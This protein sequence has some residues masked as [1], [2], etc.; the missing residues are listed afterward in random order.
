[1]RGADVVVVATT[2]QTPCCRE[3]ACAGHP[4]QRR[5]APRPTWRS[6]HD[7]VAAQGSLY[8]EQRE[9]ATRNPGSHRRARSSP[10]SARSSRGPS[11]AGNRGRDHP[12]QVGSGVA[13][14]GRGVGRSRL[15][16]ALEA[17]ASAH[18]V[19]RKPPGAGGRLAQ[20]LLRESTFSASSQHPQTARGGASLRI[21][22]G[23]VRAARTRRPSDSIS[24]RSFRI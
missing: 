19:V 18:E 17:A 8:V 15:P 3:R 2:S 6:S 1:L 20:R 11:R 16:Q 22:A 23:A 12:V 7:D 14:P 10:R 9:A 4:H 5:G 24:S 21:V 13:V